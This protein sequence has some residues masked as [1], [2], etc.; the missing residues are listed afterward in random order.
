[1]ASKVTT[2]STVQINVANNTLSN[3]VYNKEAATLE[4]IANDTKRIL[5]ATEAIIK[6]RLLQLKEL[7]ELRNNK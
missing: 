7:R 6:L 5:K 4:L 1:M 2:A 3:D